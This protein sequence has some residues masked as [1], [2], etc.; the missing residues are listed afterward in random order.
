[1]LCETEHSIPIFSQNWW[2]DAVCGAD[3]WDVS[4][5][6]K[7]GSIVGS[8]PYL[9]DSK[10][11]FTFSKMPKLTQSLGPWIKYPPKQ[12]FER[13]L[14]YEKEVING[15]LGTMPKFSYFKQNFHHSCSQNWLPLYWHDYKQ[16]TA[17][18]YVIEG[19]GDSDRVWADMQSRIKTDVKKAKERFALQVKR[20]PDVLQLYQLWELTFKR[21]NKKPPVSI[22]YLIRLDAVL[23]ERNA[24]EVFVAV[25]EQRK[26]HC[27]VYIIYDNTSAYYLISGSDPE[28]RNS[29]ALSFLLWEAISDSSKRVDCFDFEGSMLENVENFVRGFGARQKPYHKISKSTSRVTDLAFCLRGR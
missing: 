1:M 26:V 12:K 5:V 9:A 28:Y 10:F 25:D 7:G 27:G 22:D 14:S 18:T 19:I 8:W 13:R 17:Y 4:L 11:G 21:Q 3:A 16:T 6:E 2:L 23:A 24:R 15:L 29:G 20:E